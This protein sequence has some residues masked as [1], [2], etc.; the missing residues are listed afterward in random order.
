M[1]TTPEKHDNPTPGFIAEA[2]F[3]EHE[4]ALLRCAREG[5]DC[6]LYD[7]RIFKQR[8][9][10]LLKEEE[11]EPP[12][13][14]RSDWTLAYLA[15]REQAEGA[16]APE[17]RAELIRFLARGGNADHPVDP[18]G[19]RLFGA[20]VTGKLDLEACRD[21]RPLWLW[22]CVFVE[23]V[24]LSSA[25]GESVGFAG[26]LIEGTDADGDALV[27]DRL[28]TTGGVFLRDGFAAV[29]TVRLLGARIGGDL[30]CVGG[31]FRGA[32]VAL[33]A[34][35]L[36]TT[37]SVF[38]RDGFEAA[39]TVQLLGARIGGDLVCDGGAFR[40]AG[41]SLHLQDVRVEGG[42]FLRGLAKRPAGRIDLS[43]ARVGSLVDDEA[44]WPERGNLI[45][46][47]FRY[48]R[49]AGGADTPTGYAARKRWLEL[50]PDEHLHR[51]FRPQ[52]F[53]QLA[54]TLKE[55]GHTEDAKRIA[56]LK[57][58]RQRRAAHLQSR[59]RGA[60]IIAERR[61]SRDPAVIARAPWTGGVAEAGLEWLQRNLR[62]AA[63]LLFGLVVGYGYRPVYALG[64]LL[65]FVAL[66]TGIF[67]AAYEAD[68]IVPN[69][70]FLLHPEWEEA[71]D[72]DDPHAAFLEEAPDFQPFNA[73]IYSVDTFVPLVNLHQEPHWIPQ[74]QGK[75]MAWP[76]V[77]LYLWVHIAVGWVVT[78]LFAA[79]LTGL[80]Q[81][82]V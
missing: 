74:P 80:V 2:R 45:L 39:G 53:E 31:A 48:D 23:H 68:A 57:E 37:G 44:S 5:R 77:R 27:A 60:Q 81:R 58:Q 51:D 73:L 62:W 36:I 35:R 59:E 26:S 6:H 42:L 3:N 72:T 41:M 9:A 54:K 55:M 67:G 13:K 22:A 29:G 40:G 34:E 19:V 47:G 76:W 70:P 75:S 61:Y 38:L 8:L 66:G 17:I 15:I 24:N 65:V 10:K 69:N 21:L 43:A 16:R 49:L 33:D 28:T 4:V 78:A 1:A 71:L 20:R 56:I 79:S 25:G 46:D 64:W 63:S 82:D 32:K 50:Q 12:E 18:R 14:R 11:V 30:D 52:P 7:T